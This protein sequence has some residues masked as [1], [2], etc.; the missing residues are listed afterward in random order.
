MLCVR[1]LRARKPLSANS[2]ARLKL[3]R[4]RG[5]RWLVGD[6]D[7][8]LQI[9]NQTEEWELHELTPMAPGLIPQDL[10]PTRSTR[11]MLERVTRGITAFPAEFSMQSKLARVIEKRASAL[12][13]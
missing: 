6:T 3:G 1:K 5:S 8:A 10:P 9:Y 7:G 2:A 11:E 12:G 4:H 13:G